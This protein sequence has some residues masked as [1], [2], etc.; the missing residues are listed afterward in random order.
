MIRDCSR[1]TAKEQNTNDENMI[2]GHTYAVFDSRCCVF[3]SDRSNGHGVGLQ[4][5]S[6]CQLGCIPG[7]C[8]SFLVNLHKQVFNFS[9]CIW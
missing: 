7:I 5:F 2:R 9:R 4:K 1:T 3:V 6:P 8:C